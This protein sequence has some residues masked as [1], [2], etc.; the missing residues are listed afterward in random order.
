MRNEGTLFFSQMWFKSSF[1]KSAGSKIRQ[2]KPRVR[3]QRR[4]ELKRQNEMIQ[5]LHQV[6]KQ[7]NSPVNIP[8]P[9]VDPP[10]LDGEV[11]GELEVVVDEV[12]EEWEVVVVAVVEAVAELELAVEV[13]VEAELEVDV[14]LD[15]AVAEV[16]LAPDPLRQLSEVPLVIKGGG[17]D[18]I[19][20]E[21]KD[22]Y[23]W[24]TTGAEKAVVPVPS[25]SLSVILVPEV[26]L[27]EK[28]YW[29]RPRALE[30]WISLTQSK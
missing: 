28:M 29:M 22:S 12:A 16:V 26:K 24:I 11:D 17:W 13:V 20:I 21:S 9:L 10:T 3:R 18:K 2:T 7:S 14:A 23:G 5:R 6:I 8:A 19:A 27:L 25:V 15:D 1:H 30:V 4:E